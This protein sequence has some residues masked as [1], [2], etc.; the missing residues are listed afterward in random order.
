MCSQAAWINTGTVGFQQISRSQLPQLHHK[1]T[2]FRY[3]YHE[4]CILSISLLN[5]YAVEEQIKSCVRLYF[6]F[7]LLSD[8]AADHL[9]PL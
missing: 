8:P 3:I 9:F 1:M 7:A 5:L 6:Y 4:G 2:M